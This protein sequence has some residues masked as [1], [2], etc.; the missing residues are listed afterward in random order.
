MPGVTRGRSPGG[1]S[2]ESETG[3]KGPDPLGGGEGLGA[4]IGEK[5]TRTS[6]EV[7]EE[8]DCTETLGQ[9]RV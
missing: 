7:G 9:G 8:S 6:G 1:S 3:T 2:Q 5:Q 4:R